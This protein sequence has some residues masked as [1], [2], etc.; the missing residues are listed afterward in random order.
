MANPLG[1]T[2]KPGQADAT[3]TRHQ[4]FF[5]LLVLPR[6]ESSPIFATQGQ[7]MGPSRYWKA[8]FQ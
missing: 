4:P 1:N 5:F 7:N 3:Q 8:R 6:Q 2:D